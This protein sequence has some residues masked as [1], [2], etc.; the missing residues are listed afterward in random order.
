[1]ETLLARANGV[2]LGDARRSSSIPNEN[3]KFPA[4]GGLKVATCLLDERDDSRLHQLI[5]HLSRTFDAASRV[6]SLTSSTTYTDRNCRDRTCVL[7][8]L[9]VCAMRPVETMEQAGVVH[10]ENGGV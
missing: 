2:R 3:R 7:L 8:L 6:V 4:L 5:R 1:M 9:S 10:A